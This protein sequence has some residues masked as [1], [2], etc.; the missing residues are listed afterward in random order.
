MINGSSQ[1]MKNRFLRLFSF[2]LE[3]N[4]RTVEVYA[5]EDLPDIFYRPLSQ[6]AFSELQELTVVLGQ[7]IVDNSND[8][9]SYCWGEKFA[10]ANFYAH[11]HG[12][13]QV[14]NVFKSVWNS[15][16]MMK[17]K[18]FAWLLLVDRLNTRDLLQRRH[19]NVTDDY[20]CELCPLH[21]YEDRIHLFFECNFSV[22]I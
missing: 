20:R 4:I 3:E 22:R 1:P 15:S 9:W 14:P 8:V 21:V 11:I 12:D 13:I 2:A 18:V 16:C 5:L 7:N 17:T 10:S 6:Q 19:W